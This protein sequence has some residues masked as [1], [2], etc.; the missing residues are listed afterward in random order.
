M[1]QPCPYI[2]S[3]VLIAKKKD[4]HGRNGARHFYQPQSIVFHTKENRSHSPQPKYRLQS[5]QTKPRITG[6][7]LTCFIV[8]CRKNNDHPFVLT[9]KK[10]KNDVRL[11]HAYLTVKSREVSQSLE[12]LA[13][14]CARRLLTASSFSRISSPLNNSNRA[15]C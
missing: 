6:R 15:N 7:I 10:D 8:R 14:I 4:I 11:R 12:L 13:R 5:G 1:K 9:K 2:G 3:V